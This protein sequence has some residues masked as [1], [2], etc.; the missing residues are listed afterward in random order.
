MLTIAGL[1]LTDN[2][3]TLRTL[4][5]MKEADRVYVELYTNTDVYAIGELEEKIGREIKR[6]DRPGV[7]AEMK[8]VE[9]AE[10][11]DVV[12]LVSGDPLS[13]TTHYEIKEQAENR[14]IEVEVL[15]A[16]SILTAV[17]ETGLNLYKFGRTVTVP[18]N[19]T[20]ESIGDHIRKNDSVGL[21]T[22]VLLDINLDGSTAAEK[23][24]ELGIEDREAVVVERAG[25]G[26]TRITVSNLSEVAEA[27]L[28][29]PPH[30]IILT[31]EKSHKEQE[32]LENHERD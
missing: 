21:H 20:P 31:G 24:L 32:Y 19:S 13:A 17:T 1:G 26:D 28:G 7:E 2:D 8:P 25:S 4:E 11:L 16:P 30:S 22:L 14:G 15:H 10:N 9:D 12:F 23:L 6:L 29:D 18:Q 3:L 5:R 27:E